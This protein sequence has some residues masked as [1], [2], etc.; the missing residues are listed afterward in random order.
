MKPQ[1]RNADAKPPSIEQV[2]PRS[3][4]PNP[5]NAKRH[6]DDQIRALK[7]SIARYG[8]TAPVLIDSAGMILAGHGRTRAAIDAGLATIPA[9]RLDLSA[10]DARAY[11]L[12][13]NKLAEL[14][15]GWDLEVLRQELADLST[16]PELETGFSES[17]IQ[18]LLHGIT[19]KLSREEIEADD[20]TEE[21]ADK[22]DDFER[23]L[24]KLNNPTLPLVAAYGETQQAFLIVCDNEIDEAWLRHVLKLEEPRESYKNHKF[25]SANVVT[26]AELRA[27]W[28][29]R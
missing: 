29:S 11:A 14:G 8:F 26:V 18:T 15:G 16:M 17:E 5:R 23:Q 3:L 27:S 1:K 2:D 6:D 13:D 10:D 20:V 9:I 28:T 24:N 12:A 4:T 22:P 7:A 25:Q 19:R 21:P